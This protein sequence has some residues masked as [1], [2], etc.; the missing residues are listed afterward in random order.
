MLACR[1]SSSMLARRLSA[2]IAGAARGSAASAAAASSRRVGL[3]RN[4]YG[5]RRTHPPGQQRRAVARAAPPEC[6]PLGAALAA[7]KGAA[8][9]GGSEAVALQSLPVAELIGG[10]AKEQEGVEGATKPQKRADKSSWAIAARWRRLCLVRRHRPRGSRRVPNKQL[11]GAG[12]VRL[13]STLPPRQEQEPGGRDRD[14]ERG[15]DAVVS[16]GHLAII[17]GHAHVLSLPGVRRRAGM[18][19]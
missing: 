13:R 2:V 15:G 9:A 12:D 6:R 8:S 18:T 5:S 1:C 3:G 11:L 17:A 7:A 19:S 16:G 10:A 4:E 14:G